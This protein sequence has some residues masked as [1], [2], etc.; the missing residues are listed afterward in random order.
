MPPGR[1]AEWGVEAAGGRPAE[2]GRGGGPG[3]IPTRM[4]AMSQ[5][6]R[7]TTVGVEALEARVVQTTAPYINVV[8][9]VLQVVGDA[10]KNAAVVDVVG[11]NLRVT[12]TS[13]PTD[14]FYLVDPTKTITKTVA[15]SSV[16]EVKFWGY[17]N[18]DRFVNNVNIKST[19]YGGDGNDYLEG[20][21]AVDVFYGGAGNDTLK[22]YGG[23]DVL[24][25]GSGDDR[26]DGGSGRD[27]LFG[28]S[29]TDSLT[30]EAGEVVS[31]AESIDIVNLPGG[32]PQSTNTCGPNS[33]WRVIRSLGGTATLQ[34]VID[35]ASENSIVSRWNLGT[36]GSTLVTAMNGLRRGLGS[37]TFSL[38]TRSGLDTML[39]YVTQ[40]RPV[41]AMVR[42]AGK[43][44]YTIGGT[45]GGIIGK[46]PGVGGITRY[47][48]PALHWV[49]VDGY[50]SAKRLVSFTDTDGKH[51]QESYESFRGRWD[52]NLGTVQN[53]IFQG[54][55]VVKGTFIV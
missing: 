24:Y 12:M 21:N 30:C 49:A 31:G 18:D 8:N 6:I 16:R 4:T 17:A 44:V 29:G 45:V 39:S 36:T 35:K 47:E 3:Q 13:T 43:E 33:A 26:L 5:R 46:I 14:G 38:K 53:Q 25:G 15:A 28:E 51:Y 52:W 40:G 19:A 32:S 34:Q 54:L 55:G 42:V 10:Q 37:T 50:D 9:G 11:S 23:D 41:V 22:G 1:F 27:Q 7:R 2:A 20:A 48:L